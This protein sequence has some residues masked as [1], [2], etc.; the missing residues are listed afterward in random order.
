MF[1]KD[2]ISTENNSTIYTKINQENYYNFREDKNL[3][4]NCHSVDD[5]SLFDM[6]E[7]VS[8]INEILEDDQD[9]CYTSHIEESCR[10]RRKLECGYEAIA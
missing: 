9:V 7:I 1:Q 4:E 3:G 8:R 6:T 10:K 2:Y 5:E